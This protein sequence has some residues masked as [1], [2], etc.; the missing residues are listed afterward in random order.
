MVRHF[1]VIYKSQGGNKIRLRGCVEMDLL[2]IT[3]NYAVVKD[4][5]YLF[6]MAGRQW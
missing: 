1:A 5:D 6:F 3:I 2:N 4:K